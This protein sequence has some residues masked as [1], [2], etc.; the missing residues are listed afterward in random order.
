MIDAK[1]EHAKKV[2]WPTSVR[3]PAVKFETASENTPHLWG[4]TLRMAQEI[5]GMKLTRTIMSEEEYQEFK[6]KQAKL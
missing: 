6:N 2:P 4:M 5:V 1:A 3:V